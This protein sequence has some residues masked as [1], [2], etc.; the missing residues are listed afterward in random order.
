MWWIVTQCQRKLYLASRFNVPLLTLFVHAVFVWYVM[1]DNLAFCYGIEEI[2]KECSVWIGY[3]LSLPTSSFILFLC[4]NVIF[5]FCRTI[6]F[7]KELKKSLGKDAIHDVC[8][9]QCH[10]SFR[11]TILACQGI[12]PWTHAICQISL[13]HSLHFFKPTKQ[14]W[15]C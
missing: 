8:M 3:I 14:C 5:C 9:W 10:V 2:L 4:W 15:P 7:L 1:S 6:S 13:N 11:L 12:G